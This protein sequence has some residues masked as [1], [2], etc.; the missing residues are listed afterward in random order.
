M[1]I[2]IDVLS[3]A[4]P[5]V[6]IFTLVAIIPVL[7]LAY[8]YTAVFGDS[9][10]RYST[11]WLSLNT[12]LLMSVGDFNFEELF[13]VNPAS[14]VLLFWLS[15]LL[16]V[17]VLINIFVAIILNAYDLILQANP[18]R[19]RRGKSPTEFSQL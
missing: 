9:L 6:T 5:S 3:K 2:L 12:I 7:G 14:A 17:F 11:V 10:Y 1:G 18:V 15:A 16:I 4:V 19:F 8:S 13:A